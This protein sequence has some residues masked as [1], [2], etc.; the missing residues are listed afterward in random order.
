MARKQDAKKRPH[1][2]EKKHKKQSRR[3]NKRAARGSGSSH[4]WPTR[5]L[6]VGIPQVAQELCDLGNYSEARDLLE[7]YTSVH[8]PSAEVLRILADVYY[9]LEEANCLC[10]VCEQLQ[11]REPS[12]EGPLMLASSYLTDVRPT[13]ALLAFQKYLTNWPDAPMAEEVRRQVADLQPLVDGMLESTPFPRDR[14][15]AFSS[16]HE[17]VLAMIGIDWQRAERTTQQLLH[18][19]PGF[20]SGMNNATQIYFQLGRIRKAV[21]F[22]LQVIGQGAEQHPCD[23]QPGA[24]LLL[25]QSPAGGG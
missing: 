13:T 9:E 18:G 20:V 17:E 1:K 6:S 11:E 4:V 21:A 2:L 10:Q 15:Y 23:R 19:C 7:N 25:D 14:R 22:A 3:N 16:M 24:H 5:Y 12:P 8:Q